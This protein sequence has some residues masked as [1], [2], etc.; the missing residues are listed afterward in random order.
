MTG[1]PARVVTTAD[2]AR[3]VV[4]DLGGDGPP[5]L[6]VHATG[7]HGR[8]WSPV[9]AA[10]RGHFHCWAPDLRGHGDSG[11][12][13]DPPDDWLG[14]RRDLEAVVADLAIAGAPAVGHSMG[15]G[16]L[17]A[18]EATRPGTFGALWV[19]EPGVAMDHEA[20][21]AGTAESIVVASRR[22]AAFP[23]RQAALERYGA[24][25]PM[26]R[27]APAA[28]RAYVEHGFRTLEDGT[29]R[30]KCL[31]AVEA[32]VYDGYLHTGIRELLPDVRCPVFVASGVARG[33]DEPSMGV[34]VVARLPHG[35][36]VDLPGLDHFGPL[37]APD[38][39]ARSILACLGP[40]G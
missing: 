26:D 30:L 29:V 12:P 6:M 39:V 28:L 23:S 18:T 15:G 21:A 31:P 25:P 24:R 9:A 7:M 5:L 20:A 38:V 32:G 3:I 14:F 19:F 35:R 4:H 17:L 11:P 10:V 2:G 40:A 33:S 27:F 22:R 36:V 13:P 8:V 34:A 37:Q 16:S 1:R